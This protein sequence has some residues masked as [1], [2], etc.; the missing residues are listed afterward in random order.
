MP[1]GYWAHGKKALEASCVT[2]VL[3]GRLLIIQWSESQ[4]NQAPIALT[5]LSMS[6]STTP[7]LSVFGT[8]AA[9]RLPSGV[10]V[11]ELDADSVSYCRDIDEQSFE[12][13]LRKGDISR[14]LTLTHQWRADA[15]EVGTNR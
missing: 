9:S 12:C 7:L 6:D 3:D 11:L 2:D 1:W 14:V 10:R 15:V 4:A 13:L 8:A 5:V